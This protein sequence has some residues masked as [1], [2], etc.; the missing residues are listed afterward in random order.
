MTSRVFIHH[1]NQGRMRT[2]VYTELLQSINLLDNTSLAKV[3]KSLCL[4]FD[5]FTTNQA[6]LHSL[7]RDLPTKEPRPPADRHR[8]GVNEESPRRVHQIRP[9]AL[10]KERAALRGVAGNVGST[11]ANTPCPTHKTC[12]GPEVRP[13]HTRH[14]QSTFDF[15]GS[16]SSKFF[17]KV[18]PEIEES[19]AKCRSFCENNYS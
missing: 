5:T 16:C 1:S 14:P 4:Q 10:V 8:V 13:S 9:L 6:T 2:R 17:Q 12:C 15:L 18:E 7:Q 19:R 11:A 3:F